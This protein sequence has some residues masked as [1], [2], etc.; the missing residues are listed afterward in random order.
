MERVCKLAVIIRLPQIS[1][2]R[3]LVVLPVELCLSR[4]ILSNR[5]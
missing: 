5:D 2:F 3:I 1:I 4:E